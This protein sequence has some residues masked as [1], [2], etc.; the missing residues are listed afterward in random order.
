MAAYLA[1]TSAWNRST[2]VA[3]R[4]A[5]LLEANQIALCAPVRLELLYSARGKADYAYLARDYRLLPDLALDHR[6][7]ALA[8]RTQ[9][10]LA[11]RAQH[12]GPTAIDLLV[13][14]VAEQHGVTVLHHDRHFEAIGRVTGQAMEWLPARGAV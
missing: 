14:A 8:E 3:G 5:E 10:A 2:V 9:R 11:E 4:W 7:T 6:T 12:R 1:D 13:A